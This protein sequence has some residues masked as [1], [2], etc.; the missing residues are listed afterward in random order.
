SATHALPPRRSHEPHPGT[1][2][3]SRALG[4]V[5]HL[6]PAYRDARHDFGWTH[7]R[8][9]PTATARRFAPPRDARLVIERDGDARLARIFRFR[10]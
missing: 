3:A 8:T 6:E 9:R 1:T 7:A 4:Y 2:K 5:L 10:L